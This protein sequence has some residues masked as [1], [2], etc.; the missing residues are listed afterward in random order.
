MRK[1]VE[2]ERVSKDEA[3]QVGGGLVTRFDSESVKPLLP[4]E[5][6]KLE[7]LDKLKDRFK[8]ATKL[9]GIIKDSKKRKEN[10]VRKHSK[11]GAV[12]YVAERK[13]EIVKELE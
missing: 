12:P 8:E 9:K 1:R 3:A 13:K 6:R 10:N 5:Q 2:Q 4:R 11:P 7:Y